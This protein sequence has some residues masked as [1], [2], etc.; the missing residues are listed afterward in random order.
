MQRWETNARRTFTVLEPDEMEELLDHVR[1]C[2]FPESV[3]AYQELGKEAGFDQIV[4]IAR[5][6]ERLNRLVILS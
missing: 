2:D 4:P 1:E 5:D 3:S 6:T